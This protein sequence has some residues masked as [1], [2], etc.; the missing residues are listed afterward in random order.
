[1]KGPDLKFYFRS[2]FNNRTVFIPGAFQKKSEGNNL[3]VQKPSIMG[4]KKINNNGKK[5]EKFYFRSDF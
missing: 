2:I 3:T 4:W 5:R 1:M